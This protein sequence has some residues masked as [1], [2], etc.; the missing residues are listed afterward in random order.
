MHECVYERGHDM[1]WIV[2]YRY[3]DALSFSFMINESE[4]ERTQLE[5]KERK[6]IMKPI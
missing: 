4:S 2:K 1:E 3:V 5:K 6:K